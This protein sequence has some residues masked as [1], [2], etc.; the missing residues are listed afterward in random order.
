MRVLIV[1]D[2]EMLR[3][4]LSLALRADGYVVEEAPTFAEGIGKSEVGQ[5]QLLLVDWNLPDGDGTDLVAAYRASGGA[6]S[7]ILITA[8]NSIEDQVVGLDAG[9]DDFISKPFLIPA[10][11]A[12]VRALM[13]RS[14][15]WAPQLFTIGD[16]TIDCDRRI[17]F[18]N[19][20]ALDL[21]PKEWQ[22][23]WFLARH[24]GRLATRAAFVREVWAEKSEP[25]VHTLEVHISNLR[26]KLSAKRSD[27]GIAARRGAGYHLV[28]QSG[29]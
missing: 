16:L 28:R 1:E 26:R 3:G 2:D 14:P 29:P 23:L 12:R 10:L 18:V 17:A 13:R 5:F 9:A 19:G 7:T 24:D 20:H 8:R 27:V 25:D 15:Q 6:A 11:R 22:V 21:T 4:L